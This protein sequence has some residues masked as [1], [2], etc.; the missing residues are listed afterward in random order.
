MA[1]A[2]DGFNPFARRESLEYDTIAAEFG[3]QGGVVT[4]RRLE[5][6]G[7]VRIYA[8]GTLDLLA[9]EQDVD[10][11]AGVFLLQRVREFLGKVPLVSWV[12]P[13][14][15]R[16]FVGAYFRITGSAE[17]PEVETMAMKTFREQLPDVIS[18]P[19]DVID[20]LWTRGE[21]DERRRREPTPTAELDSDTVVR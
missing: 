13:G 3:L 18:A 15:N 9:E 19:I 2:T 10:A 1:A 7:P 20:W 4:A 5:V 16:G 11:V 8:T 17:D 21:R 14:S 12:M 6:E